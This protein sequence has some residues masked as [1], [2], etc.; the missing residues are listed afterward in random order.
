MA[1]TM[2][3]VAIGLVFIFLLFSVFLSTVLEAVSSLFTLRAR[4]LEIAI[5]Q[6]LQD[7]DAIP[8]GAG[9]PAKGLFGLFDPLRR[10]AEA[11]RVGL[12]G[13][14]AALKADRVD[15]AHPEH[16]EA[17]TEGPE[18]IAP[19]VPVRFADVYR[20]PLVSAVPGKRPSYVST[21]NFASALL[22]TLAS[23][24]NG[25]LQSEIE[26]GI[27]ALPLGPMRTA[28]ATAFHEAEGDMAKLRQGVERWFDHAMD[29][30]SGEYK[31]FSQA[32]TFL[33]A[34]ACAVAFNIDS[35][36]LSER[37]YADSALR[38]SITTMAIDYAAKHK[39]DQPAVQPGANADPDA[40]LAAFK[41]RIAAAGQARD[42]L[43]KGLGLFK[44]APPP[45]TDSWSAG[46]AR[47][48]ANS[49]GILVTALAGMLG[50]PFWFEL[51]QRLVNLRGSG[52]RPDGKATK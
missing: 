23:G 14:P 30:L 11:I 22:H 49:I 52:P 9:G 31:R 2:L 7:Q 25:T 17:P 15:P 36:D 29:R 34:L 8:W 4:S 42:E 35:I 32:V 19:A 21:E 38:A 24:A 46:I 45:V 1:G 51:L 5:A 10:L 26:H 33:L 47:S 16:Y 3:D 20:H 43:A 12:G 44:L 41:S 37:L 40:N 50:A 18:D 13:D 6:L 39:D 27:A 48:V 28:L